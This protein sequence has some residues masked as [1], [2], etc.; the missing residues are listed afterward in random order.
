[1]LFLFL[2]TETGKGK[3]PLLSFLSVRPGNPA[4][5]GAFNKINMEYKNG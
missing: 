2:G 5:H 1:M 4:Q 3:E